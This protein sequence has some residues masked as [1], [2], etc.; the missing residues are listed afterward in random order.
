MVSVVLLLRPEF[1]S[2]WSLPLVKLLEK[3]KTL[4]KSPRMDHL[5][6]L[7]VFF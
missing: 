5:K 2:A 4:K 3:N 1:K 7:M 6:N